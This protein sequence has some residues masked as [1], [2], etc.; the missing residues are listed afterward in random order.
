M[1]ALGFGLAAYAHADLVDGTAEELPWVEWAGSGE[2]MNTY[3]ALRERY[4]PSATVQL[5]CDHVPM[6]FAALCN[7]LGAGILPCFLGE[8]RPELRRLDDMPVQTGPTL[9]LLS[10]PD[11]RGLRRV[12]VLLEFLTQVFEERR[13]WLEV[14]LPSATQT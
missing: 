12:H 2:I 1:K 13:D 14:L 9:W 10:R 11:Q 6:Q 3:R 8:E 5:R 4:F 7:G